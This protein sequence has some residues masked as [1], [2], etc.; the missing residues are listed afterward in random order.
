M[1]PLDTRFSRMVHGSSGRT[2]G[3]QLG[4]NAGNPTINI[5]IGAGEATTADGQLII[6]PA[7]TVKTV[8]GAWAPGVAGAYDGQ[9]VV[10]NSSWYYVHLIYRPDLDTTDVLTSLN[11]TAPTLPLNYTKSKRIGCVYRNSGGSI[12]AF[13]QRG[14]EFVWT[15]APVQ[16]VNY[17]GSGTSAVLRTLTVPPITG[18]QAMLRVLLS[19]PTSAGILL[20][21]SPLQ[22]DQGPNVPTGNCTIFLYSAGAQNAL[23]VGPYATVSGQIR[24][25]N[26][27]AGAAVS[28]VTVGW[29]DSRIS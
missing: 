5:D 4:N 28:I 22:S 8:A 15:V 24:D 23:A 21:T 16:D 10:T 17:T 14:D 2:W 18:I 13:T 7:A 19:H 1:T 27:I 11:P 26:G 6:L 25:R 9:A 20:I 29:L 3:C 12:S